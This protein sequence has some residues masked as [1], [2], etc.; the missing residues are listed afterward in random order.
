MRE[1][2]TLVTGAS[3]G[4]GRAIAIALSADRPLVL[5]GRDE[6]RLERTRQECSGSGHLVWMADLREAASVGGSLGDFLAGSGAKVE[7]FVHSAG[8]VDVVA[9]RLA[10]YSSNLECMNVNFLSAVEIVKT[11]L[12]GKSNGKEL[13]NVLLISSVYSKLGAK[14]QALYCASKGAADAYVRSLAAELSPR[15]RANTLLPGAVMTPIAES[16]SDDYL[17]R[18][19]EAHPLG[20]GRPEDVANYVR[21]ILSDEARWLTGQNI[22]IDGG[23]SACSRL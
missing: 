9:S 6:A 22:V 16:S 1:R 20:M 23:F 7:A 14:G 4:L 3:S 10:Q 17:K 19:A 15:V 5:H 2:Y 12:A 11:L 21:F 13:A 8:I 18:L